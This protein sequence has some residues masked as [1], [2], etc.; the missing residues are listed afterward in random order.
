MEKS[1]STYDVKKAELNKLLRLYDTALQR[2]KDLINKANKGKLRSSSVADNMLKALAIGDYNLLISQK[3][4]A[5]KELNE[6]QLELFVERK[7][8]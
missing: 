4:N 1:L 2:Q 3:K 6:L 8:Y 7:D 5:I